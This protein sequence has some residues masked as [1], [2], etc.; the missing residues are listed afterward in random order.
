MENLNPSKDTLANGDETHNAVMCE[1]TSSQSCARSSFFSVF[2]G[3]DSIAEVKDNNPDDNLACDDDK[4][5]EVKYEKNQYILT[6]AINVLV[7][8]VTL[9]QK[10][11]VN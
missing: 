4:Y 2:Y 9:K 5:G 10:P 8:N 1:F 6:H 11:K 7:R 3:R